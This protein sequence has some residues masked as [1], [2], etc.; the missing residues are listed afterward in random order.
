MRHG[1]AGVD[2]RSHI[3][4]V[5]AAWGHRDW[6]GGGAFVVEEGGFAGPLEGGGGAEAAFQFF[7]GEGF[8]PVDFG[9]EGGEEGGVGK[10][11]ERVEEGFRCVAREEQE[12][13]AGFGEEVVDC[14]E[15]WGVGQHAGGGVGGGRGD[16]GS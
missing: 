12:V 7:R 14:D 16:V 1:W 8:E 10:G 15:G 13:D 2:S 3:S 11:F 9:L 6:D 4:G 5:V